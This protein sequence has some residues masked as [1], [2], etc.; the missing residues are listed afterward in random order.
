MNVTTPGMPPSKPPLPSSGD[1]VYD[2]KGERATV[3]EI[4][5]ADE[6]LTLLLSGEGKRA[7]HVP[8]SLLERHTEGYY[9][10]LVFNELGDGADGRSEAVHTIPV[11]QETIEVSKK[12]VD[13]GT[14][15]R[16]KKTIEERN[17]DVTMQLSH[18]EIEVEHIPIRKIIPANELPAARQEGDVY[19]VPVFKEV[20]V[21]EKK[22]CLEEEVHIKRIRKQ[23]AE[24][25]SIPL[26]SEGVTI[27]RFD[28][29]KSK[30]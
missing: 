2:A 22:I 4:Q 29:S 19:I 20:L 27:E 23:R 3:Q 21:V 16:I 25:E 11:R 30:E 18:D 14:G 9:L 10:P 17:E 6:N 28:E 24:T 15:V 8:L 1:V 5:G 26:K 7:L 12:A 13:K